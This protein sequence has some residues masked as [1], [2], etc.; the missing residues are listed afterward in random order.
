[1]VHELR[2][3]GEAILPGQC[4][5]GVGE[6]HRL[7]GVA[8]EVFRLLAQLF[9]RGTLGELPR[10]GCVGHEISFHTPVSASRAER[11]SE[12]YTADSRQ[13]GSALPADGMRP[14]A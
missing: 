12:L 13:V 3:A 9:E 14:A 6:P 10:G 8:G 4:A 2:P 7:T 1:M 5:L 11:R